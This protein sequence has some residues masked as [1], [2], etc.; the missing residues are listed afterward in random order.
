M[1]YPC[2]DCVVDFMYYFCSIVS[3]GFVLITPR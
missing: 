2:E 1:N 3:D